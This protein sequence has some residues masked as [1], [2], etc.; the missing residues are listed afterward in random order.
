MTGIDRWL[1]PVP[2][3]AAAL[4]FDLADFRSTVT[5][6]MVQVRVRMTAQAFGTGLDLVPANITTDGRALEVD[7]G[8]L[9]AANAGARDRLEA[10]PEGAVGYLRALTASRA[11]LDREASAFGARVRRGR[12]PAPGTVVAY[13]GAAA[14]DQAHGSLKFCLPASLRPT[15]VRWLGDEAT[16]AA[17][18]SPDASGMWTDLRRR[19]LALA[20]LRRRGPAAQYRMYLAGHR[21]AF[22]YLYAEDVDFRDHESMEAI[23]ARIAGLGAVAEQERRLE[24][25]VTAERAA[26]VQARAR[27]A[28]VVAAAAAESNGT[29]TVVAQVLLARALAAHEDHNRR[30]KMRLLRDLRDHAAAAGLDLERA[31]LR[32]FAAAEEPSRAEHA[33]LRSP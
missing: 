33:V 22:G 19:E 32:D 9:E 8:A 1:A 10:G 24:E 21:R 2:L 6:E 31:G 3:P 29:A 23:D 7:A 4:R 5:R 28:E 30:A 13:V 15:L 17:L 20:G 26:K 18:L 14:H 11:A 27:F 25:A 16:T 12:L